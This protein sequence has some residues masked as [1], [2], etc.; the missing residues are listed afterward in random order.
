MNDRA[1]TLSA[2][3]WPS[4]VA[5]SLV[6][7]K[8]T[9]LSELRTAGNWIFWLENRPEEK[10]RGVVVG[11]SPD[12]IIHD[13]TPVETDVGS[14]VHEY[15]GGAWDVRL[16]GETPS[17]AFSDR[18][19]GGLWYVEDGQL[20]CWCPAG[21]MPEN[22]YADITFDPVGA[23]VFCVQ[24]SHSIGKAEAAI[25][26]V[27]SAGQKA[28]LVHGA[29]FYAAPR[30]SPD[31][32]FL[33]WFSWD[34]PEMPWTATRLDV[35]VLQRATMELGVPHQLGGQTPCSIIEPRWADSA[36]L[37]ATSDISGCWAPIRFQWIGG[38][39]TATML[40]DAR[41][42][43]G[44]PHW[45]FSQRTMTPLPDGCLLALGIRHGLNHVLRFDGHIWEEL[46]LGAPVNVP[47]RLVDGR[48]AW[49][50][51]PSE[52]PPAIAVGLPETGFERFRESVILPPGITGEDIAAPQPL[53]FPT[54][55]GVE[56]HALFYPPSSSS[57]SLRP[58]E[59]PPLVVMAH[60]GP[61]GRANPG[62]AFK[63]QWWTSRG[64]AV[65]DVNYRGSTG[66]GRAYR[67][68]LDGE[69]GV[70]DVEDCLA[71]VR[72]V[73]ERDL[74]DP[75]RCVIRGSSA[76][77]LTVLAALA[78]SDLF[79]AG[80][81]LYGVTD[82]RA[83]AA[84]THKFEAR[85][86]DRLIGPYPQDEA[87]YLERS[88]VTQAQSISVP[89]LFL[90]GGADNV[91][92]LAQAQAMCT[93]LEHSELH[94]YPEEGHGFRTSSSIEDSLTRELAFY[95]KVLDLS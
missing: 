76:G 15:G 87:V 33:A 93:K 24:E 10:G 72:A 59:K 1:H 95:R 70:A 4:W 66:F 57:S 26:H 30:P 68:A 65:L 77:G 69:W 32:H 50:D 2:G 92:P 7:G 49:I 90:H 61:T 37:Y 28:T 44:L 13:L 55:N 67:E 19:K 47:E 94:V 11:R 12:G 40:P 39:W 53:T 74:V 18:R 60:G 89:V 25:I 38:E 45:V 14:R 78:Q 43:I 31:G 79:A 29:D 88:P 35:A 34:D 23:S 54:T 9:S 46:L 20:D 21:N 27:N 85:Y 17:I 16:N 42:E 56:A 81:S 51:A 3:N 6:A 82:L 83:L 8:T 75:S 63:V 22:R 91:V 84:E 71:G 48:L 52:A 64:F 62:F 36:T 86:L 80:T 5:P 73:V 41:A 58:D